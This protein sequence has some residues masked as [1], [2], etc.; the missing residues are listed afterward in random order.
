M[1]R[2]LE[3]YGVTSSERVTERLNLFAELVSEHAWITEPVF[4]RAINYCVW[5][6]D[7]PC[8]NAAR[9]LEVC[10]EV[11]AE[12]DR[13]QRRA[14]PA[15]APASSADGATVRVDVTQPPSDEGLRDRLVRTG[16]WDRNVA[17]GKARARKRAALVE[18]WR[19]QT[20]DAP[21][22]CQVPRWSRDVVEPA[23]A[24]VDAVLHELAAAG[25][26]KGP[27][28]AALAWR[29]GS[30]SGSGCT[31]PHSPRPA[32]VAAPEWPGAA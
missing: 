14:L 9:F 26:L 32:A 18:A 22:G 25:A 2:F 4:V 12:A 19:R 15:P 11:K 10:R 5:K 20:G 27:L 1:R 23:D 28:E 6:L 13:E 17:I 29:P 24:E 16:L 21:P 30:G 7:G 3:N 31:E 8:P